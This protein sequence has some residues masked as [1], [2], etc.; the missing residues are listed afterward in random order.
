MTVVLKGG[1]ATVYSGATLLRTASA[2]ELDGGRVTVVM[3]GEDGNAVESDVR[4][5]PPGVAFRLG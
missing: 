5:L 4:S 1:A 3:T 2:V